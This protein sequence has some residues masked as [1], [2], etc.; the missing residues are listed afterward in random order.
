MIVVSQVYRNKNSPFYSPEKSFETLAKANRIAPDYE[1]QMQLARYYINGFGTK[2]NLPE[3][4]EILKKGLS[5]NS[6]KSTADRLLVQLYY[7]YDIKDYVDEKTIID[8]LKNDVI[9][10]KTIH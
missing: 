5:K 7:Q 10:R 1:S 3:A 4:V 6:Y 2:Q 8:I 9:E